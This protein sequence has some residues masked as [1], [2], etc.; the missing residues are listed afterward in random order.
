MLHDIGKLRVPEDIIDKPGP[1]TREERAYV[2]RHSYDTG[3]ILRK[4]FPGQPIAD[5][6]AMHHE[7]LLGTGYPFHRPP[8]ELPREA[9]LI[10]VADIFQAMSQERPYRGH[11]AKFEVMAHLDEL[12]QQGRIDFEMVALLHTQLDPCY[13]LAVE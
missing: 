6:A 5:W 12:S 4:V 1:L 3:H 8:I 11:M 2:M 9:R 13:A 7:N 10:T